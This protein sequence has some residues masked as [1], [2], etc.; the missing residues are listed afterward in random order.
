M[1]CALVGVQGSLPVADYFL[2][3]F[4]ELGP[5]TMGMLGM[6]FTAVIQQ[7]PARIARLHRHTELTLPNFPRTLAAWQR[8]HRRIQRLGRAWEKRGARK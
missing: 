5:F 7:H 1:T 2:I 8:N 4:S 3:P 6:T